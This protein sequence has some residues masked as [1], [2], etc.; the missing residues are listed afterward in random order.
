[1]KYE[2]GGF[3]LVGLII[4]ELIGHKTSFKFKYSHCT[5]GKFI[6]K[7]N[8]LQDLLSSLNAVILTNE[9]TQIYKRLCDL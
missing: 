6:C 1:M 4:T 2:F 3:H 5:G 9:S 8:P 7:R